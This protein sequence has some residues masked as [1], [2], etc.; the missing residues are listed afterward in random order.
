MIFLSLVLAACSVSPA[1]LLTRADFTADNVIGGSIINQKTGDRTS[2][3]QQ[4]I[5]KIFSAL[6]NMSEPRTEI[7]DHTHT[8][9]FYKGS[10]LESQKLRFVVDSEGEGYFAQG[11]SREVRFYSSDLERVIS[12]YQ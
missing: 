1:R 5:N 4:E 11:N 12:N 7:F 3:N 9:T 6:E 8:I 10:S 2:L